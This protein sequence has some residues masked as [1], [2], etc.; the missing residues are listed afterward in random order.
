MVT[1]NVD[2]V[3]CRQTIPVGELVTF[4][5]PVNY[6]GTSFM[7]IGIKVIAEEIRTPNVRHVDSCCFTMVAVD[8][9]RKPVAVKL[10][11]PESDDERR[12]HAAAVLRREMRQ[13]TEKRVGDLKA[14]ERAVPAPPDEAMLHEDLRLFLALGDGRNMHRVAARAQAGIQAVTNLSSMARSSGDLPHLLVIV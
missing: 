4:L 11:Q 13:K 10:W 14:G 6:T 2:Q 3:M 12:R 9:N 7:E 1:L 8:D 5:A